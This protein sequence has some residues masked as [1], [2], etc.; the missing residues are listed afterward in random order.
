MIHL[1]TDL[2]ATRYSVNYSCGCILN[3]IRIACKK[4]VTLSSQD[5]IKC[6]ECGHSILYKV[7]TKRSIKY[8]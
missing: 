4:I 6:K 7:R 5:A 1:D 8:N 2:P 3:K